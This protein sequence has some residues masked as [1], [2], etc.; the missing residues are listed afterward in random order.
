MPLPTG[1]AVTFL[2]TDIEGS[3]RLER[4]VG[5]AAWAGIVARHDDLNRPAGRDLDAI[6]ARLERTR[7]VAGPMI[8]C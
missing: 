5:S 1:P 3:T 8:R 2:F 6:R 7:I 4:A